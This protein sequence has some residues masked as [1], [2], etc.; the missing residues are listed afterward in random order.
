M[1]PLKYPNNFWRNFEMPLINCEMNLDVN[2]SKNCVIAAKNRD[3]DIKCSITD[4]KLYVSVVTLSTQD[5][6]KLREQLKYGFNR[7]INW[8]RHQSKESTE[9]QN[10][11]LD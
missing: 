7:T 6:A 8:N 3:Q 2:C 5:N 11:Y 1:V 10:K 4:T 9:R